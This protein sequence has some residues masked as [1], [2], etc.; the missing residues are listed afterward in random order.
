MPIRK[1]KTVWEGG[2]RQGKGVMELES[3][4]FQGPYS[5]GFVP[6]REGTNP[7]E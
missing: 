2:F 4:A 7:E 5:S 6:S 3:Q 1:A